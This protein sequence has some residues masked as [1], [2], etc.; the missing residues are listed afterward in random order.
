MT[1]PPSCGTRREGG[2][3]HVRAGRCIKKVENSSN[4]TK[5]SNIPPLL[6]TPPPPTTPPPRPCAILNKLL[7]LAQPSLPQ[8]TP[9]SIPHRHTEGASCAR[10]QF[11]FCQHQGS[12]SLSRSLALSRTPKRFH[13]QELYSTSANFRG[14]GFFVRIRVWCFIRFRMTSQASWS[15]RRRHQLKRLARKPR[16]V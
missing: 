2:N 7:L 13:V 1:T 10:A 6:Q 14:V 9:H 3:E 12:L 5:R 8:H 11:D 15:L 4:E 16:V